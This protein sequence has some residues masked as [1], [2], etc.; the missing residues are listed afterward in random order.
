MESFG[1]TPEGLPVDLYV[2]RNS[3]G[4]VVKVATYGGVIQQ[5]LAPDRDGNL[6]DIV[7]GF[8][9]LEGYLAGNP[10]YFGAIIGRYANRIARG[11]FVLGGETHVVSQNEGRNSLHGGRVGFDKRVW[12]GSVIGSDRHAVGVALRCT[13]PDGEM[14]YPGTL[15]V[16]V[17]Y[18][19]GDNDSLRID[20]R[21]TTDR[22]TVVNL[23]NHTLW[24][25]AGEGS[26]TVDDHVLTLDADRYTPVD[27][28][29]IPTGE[30]A[31]VAGT[32]LAFTQP[33]PVGEHRR[34]HFPQIEIAGGFD[35][36]YVI[37]R[38]VPGSFVRAA[39]VYEPS[40]GRAVTVF[41]TEPGIQLYS[42]QH[43][44][45][46]SVGKSGRSYQ[47]WDGVALETQHFPDSPNR[48]EF[49]ST[50]LRPGGVFSSSTLWRLSTRRD[51]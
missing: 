19:L 48:P 50:V 10:W 9:T 51:N 44:D 11:T 8:E 46:S 41:T 37:N 12:L 25:L 3:S 6:A 26:G 47:A 7:L 17:T 36:N 34:D 35:F 1:S 38:S 23:T 29:L 16:L 4:L 28:E 33:T 45:G 15:S 18:S 2:L 13:S 30:I 24:N 22:E 27:E 43:L 5:I 32:P 42:G 39:D 40:S 31:S 49:P 14:G 20:Y 21:A